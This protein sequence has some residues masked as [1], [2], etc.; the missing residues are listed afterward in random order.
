MKDLKVLYL[1]IYL[2]G[3]FQSQLRYFYKPQEK[4]GLTYIT[5]PDVKKYVEKKKPSL[6]G[7]DFK[8]HFSSQG[9]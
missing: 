3:R 5:M 4:G 6:K 9:L 2:N 1:D 8:V 7:K